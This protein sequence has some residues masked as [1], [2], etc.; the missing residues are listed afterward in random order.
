MNNKV[1]WGD[2]KR[3]HPVSRA[4]FYGVKIKDGNNGSVVNDNSGDYHASGV[5]VADTTYYMA[6]KYSKIK[7]RNKCGS[8]SFSPNKATVNGLIFFAAMNTKFEGIKFTT[9]K[10]SS[11]ILT[12][13]DNNDHSG[14]W[15]DNDYGFYYGLL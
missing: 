8:T 10:Y 6:S 15:C 14:C 12:H 13:C 3:Y 4:G 11:S 2:P 1:K 7:I 9:S 5:F